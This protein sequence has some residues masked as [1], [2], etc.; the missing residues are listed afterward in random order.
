MS[1]RPI[2][3]HN[4]KP[5]Y[6]EWWAGVWDGT[7]ASDLDQPRLA[8][9]QHVA[10]TTE[11]PTEP[12]TSIASYRMRHDKLHDGQP[13]ALVAGIARLDP[14]FFETYPGDKSAE[15]LK[16][17]VGQAMQGTYAMEVRYSKE[18][19]RKGTAD[20]LATLVGQPLGVLG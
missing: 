10:A 3:Q 18:G 17:A 1:T 15:G 8:V 16:S 7:L 2:D 13:A 4:T 9:L 11:C 6:Y 14:M 5:A 19:L 12:G 20:E